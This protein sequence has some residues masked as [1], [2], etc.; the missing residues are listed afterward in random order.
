MKIIRWILI[1]GLLWFLVA[2]KQAPESTDIIK[3]MVSDLES[4]NLKMV[5]AI[6]DSIEKSN[7][8]N[9]RLKEIADSLSDISERIYLDFPYSEK[10]VLLDMEKRAVIFSQMDKETWEKRGWLESRIIDG[11]KR[12]FSRAVTNLALLR[13]FH[14]DKKGWNE[15]NVNDPVNIF[16]LKNTSDI[17]RSSSGKMDPSVPVNMMITYTITVDADAVPDGEIVRCW[18][19]W[20]KNNLPRQRNVELLETSM[21]D[22]VISPDSSIHSTLY[23]EQKTKKSTPSVFKIAFKYQ[24]SGQYFDPDNIKAEKYDK[25]SELFKKYTSE[26]PPQI[27]FSEKVRHL[28]DSITAGEN[29]PRL[30]VKKIYNWFKENIPWAGALE[31]SIMPDIPGYVIKNR[32]GDCGMQTLLYISM[33]RYK[34]IPVRWQSGWMVPEI[35]K[36]LHDWCEIYYEGTGWVPSDISYD[37]QNS[38]DD[39]VRNFF[40]SGIDSY[41]LILNDGISGK[42]FPEKKFY[43]SEPYDFQR[44]EVEWKGG[45]LYFDKWSYDMKIEY[46]K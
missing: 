42:L 35:G 40:I 12:Y 29:D 45:N 9:T 27:R 19:P 26:Q 4:G 32:R 5:I 39:K 31:Y 28:A 25:N 2:C 37:L 1:C 21:K 11:E 17:V 18:M 36:N 20:P 10:Q 24:S 14:E 8:D 46:L 43:R 30:E 15:S 44:G 41:R 13:L 34:G 7:T 23:M 33:L 6:A 16:R 22:Y 3:R 38:G